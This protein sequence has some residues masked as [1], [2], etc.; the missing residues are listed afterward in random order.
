VLAVGATTE[1]G[2]MSRY[3]NYGSDLDVV[4]PGGGADAALA[5]DPYCEAGRAG[6]PIYQ[7]GLDHLPDQFGIGN[8]YIGTSMAAPEVSAIA[9]LVVA[10][11]VLGHN[12]SPAEITAHIEQ[13]SRDLGPVGRDPHYGWGLVD[14]GAATARH[15][16]KRLPPTR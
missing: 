1:F 11:G 5:D 9:A 10:S 16:A 13:T 15:V 2:C 12:P 4:A 14:A 3:S 8:P 6:R 7:V